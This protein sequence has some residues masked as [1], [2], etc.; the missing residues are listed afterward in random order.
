MKKQLLVHLTEQDH[1]FLR[2]ESFET[3]LPMAEI[4]RQ[5]LELYKTQK[6]ME[7]MT[8][9]KMTWA[10]IMEEARSRATRSGL[11]T[12]SEEEFEKD[13]NLYLVNDMQEVI[14]A[15]AKDIE[16]GD[17]KEYDEPAEF[18]KAHNIE[19]K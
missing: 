2:K 9:T 10:E 13:E 3:G 4:M 17:A 12:D 16:D 15:F 1:D 19:W 14:N 5:G 8:N 7:E 11:F 18:L 6:E